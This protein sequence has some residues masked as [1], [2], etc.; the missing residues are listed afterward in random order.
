[1][2]M[3]NGPGRREN[4]KCSDFE[5]DV[6]SGFWWWAVIRELSV[7]YSCLPPLAVVYQYN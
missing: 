5:V 7:V 2:G 6:T 1:M 4:C 3:F